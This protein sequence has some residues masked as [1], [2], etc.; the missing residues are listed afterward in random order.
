M[1]SQE[2]RAVT[3]L[4][5][6]FSLRMLGLF[7]VLPLLAL[8]G[9][10]LAGSTPLLLGLALGIYGLA[11]AA[12]QIPLGLLSDR[13]GRLPVLVGGLLVFLFGSLVAA[14]ADS[15]YVVI[16]GR[17]LQ[18][19][20]AIS[21]TVMALVAD[22]TRDEQRT[23]AMALVGISIGLAFAVA[24]VLGPVLASWGGLSLVFYATAV[25]VAGGIVVVLF[26][27]PR[28]RQVRSVHGEVGTVPGLI[29]RSLLDPG[30]ARLNFGVF[31]LHFILMAS[32]VVLP[33]VLEGQLGVHRDA[34]W[35][36]YLPVLLLSIVGMVPL[37]MLAER[38]GRLRMAFLTAIAAL[39]AAQWLLSG[40]WGNTGFYLGLW[41]F[42]V[43]FNYL[44]ASLPSL[45]SKTVYAG[46][47][48]TALGVYS[49]FQFF[50]AFAG[51]A[52]GGIAMQY[53]GIGAV[54]ALCAVL[55]GIWAAV[56][57]FM[58]RPPDLVNHVVTLSGHKPAA[59]ERLRGL[60]AAA[61]VVDLLLLEDEGKVYLKVDE[62]VFDPV[63]LDEPAT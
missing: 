5:G 4:A 48:G 17:F 8:Y 33:Q 38:L 52:C 50:G 21:S 7:M 28:V 10:D 44:E 31:T 25:L 16:L 2:R 6:L 51:G 42:F 20:G 56:A 35:R 12:L 14:Q 39:I 34:H 26:A 43:G 18:G 36:I 13:I 53:A 9:A 54:F 45:V 19:A 57:A 1:N 30:L 46:G 11:Q 3:A 60:Q 41:V 58:Q 23:K 24:L 49:T 37:M 22:L 61:G 27:V 15:I 40:E 59:E 32:F 29:R 55:A 62:A 63:L 47:K